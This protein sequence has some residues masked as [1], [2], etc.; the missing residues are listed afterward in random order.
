MA[1]VDETFECEDAAFVLWWETDGEDRTSG[2]D[3]FVKDE[4]IDET[5]PLDMKQE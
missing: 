3:T 5:F 1:G 4:W 2:D